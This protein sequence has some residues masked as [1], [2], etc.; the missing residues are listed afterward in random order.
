MN[1]WHIDTLEHGISLGINPNYY[2]H[3]IIQ[4]TIALNE[5]ESALPKGSVLSN[6]IEDIQGLPEEIK[7]KLEKRNQNNNN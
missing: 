3:R 7:R 4:D 6:E 1:I 2:F 5:Q